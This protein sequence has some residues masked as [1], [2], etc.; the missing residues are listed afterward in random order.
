MENTTSVN[1]TVTTRECKAYSKKVVTFFFGV[2]PE[3]GL[4]FL[5]VA[6][7]RS[8]FRVVYSEQDWIQILKLATRSTFDNDYFY[9]RAHT[10]VCT[11]FKCTFEIYDKFQSKID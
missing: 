2:R 11:I 7:A 6:E 1:S 10:W 5:H 8:V 9:L 4:S 3:L